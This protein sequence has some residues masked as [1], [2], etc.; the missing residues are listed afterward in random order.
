MKIGNSGQN[1]LLRRPKPYADEDLAGY[2]LRLSQINSYSS[3]QWIY[4]LVEV[5]HYAANGNFFDRTTRD[6]SK[7]A[8]LLATDESTLWKMAFGGGHKPK[9]LLS[10]EF[11]GRSI[12]TYNFQKQSAKVCPCCL[13]KEAYCRKIW[14]L[15]SL[16]VCPI[17]N[18]LLLDACPQCGR[19]IRWDRNSVNECKYCQLDWRSIQPEIRKLQDTIP[20]H[21][22]FAACGLKP[23]GQAELELIGAQHPILN[24]ELEDLIRLLSFIAGQLV[25]VC[26]SI[27]KFVVTNR[28]NLELHE[29]LF[30]AWDYLKDFPKSVYLQKLA[31]AIS[32]QSVAKILGVGRKAVVDLIEHSCLSAF[33]GRTVDGYLRWLIDRDAPVKLLS[34]IDE[35]LEKM[36]DTGMFD[37]CS[38]DLAIRKLSGSG[39]SIVVL[40]AQS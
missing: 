36:A 37:E 20:F 26:D 24:L 30:S 4:N 6:L 7:L 3:P 19:T 17:H 10:I 22:I 1:I 11:F 12:A 40:F 18:C 2:I 14:N 23:L 31:N 28:N 25:D 27:G 8:K 38:F 39:C 13:E 9:E 32:T 33:R 16:T 34:R 35:L 5:S 29:L 21:I 15:V